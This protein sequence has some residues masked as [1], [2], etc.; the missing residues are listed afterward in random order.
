MPTCHSYVCFGHAAAKVQEMIAFVAVHMQQSISSLHAL[1]SAHCKGDVSLITSGAAHA[2]VPTWQQPPMSLDAA[3]SAF[4]TKPPEEVPMAC[5]ASCSHTCLSHG[6]SC[7][8]LCIPTHHMVR[9]MQR[10][11]CAVC[12]VPASRMTAAGTMPVQASCGYTR[13]PGRAEDAQK[14]GMEDGRSTHIPQA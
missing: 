13:L 1:E 3:C 7:L 10:R 11:D 2:N 4:P 8:S 6:T 12:A 5:N 9:R 14:A